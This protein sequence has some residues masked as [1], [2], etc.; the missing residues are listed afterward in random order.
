MEGTR[1]PEERVFN[2]GIHHPSQ[3]LHGNVLK[4][5]ESVKLDNKANVSVLYMYVIIRIQIETSTKMYTPF[6]IGIN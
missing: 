6:L 3:M 1:C 5:N 4:S 2:V